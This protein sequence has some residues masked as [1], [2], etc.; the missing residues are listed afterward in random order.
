MLYTPGKK[1]KLF[2][3]KDPDGE[4]NEVVLVNRG[5][6]IGIGI[7]LGIIVATAIIFFSHYWNIGIGS[8]IIVGGLAAWLPVYSDQKREKYF[9]PLIDTV[10]DRLEKLGHTLSRR[11]VMDLLYI[12]EVR[13]SDEHIIFAET[14]RKELIISVC[15]NKKKRRERPERKEFFETRVVGEPEPAEEPDAVQTVD[16][17]EETTE[18]VVEETTVE[19]ETEPEEATVQEETEPEETTVEET[20]PEEETELEEAVSIDETAE[21]PANSEEIQ[22]EAALQ[23]EDEVSEPDTEP[24]PSEN[25]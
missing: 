8:G 22:E 10:Q 5:A 24:G 14:L 19:E 2:A 15:H 9:S 21:E 12:R 7:T 6:L 13:S 18:E 11:Q 16:T 17:V 3:I 25:R 1:E 4:T 23:E 20:E